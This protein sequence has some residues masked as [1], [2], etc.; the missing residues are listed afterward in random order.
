MQAVNSYNTTSVTAAQPTISYNT[1]S[2]YP[3]NETNGDSGYN[4]TTVT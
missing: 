4:T 3:T 2:V 1:T